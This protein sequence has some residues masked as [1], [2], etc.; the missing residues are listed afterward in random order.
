MRLFSFLISIFITLL[1]FSSFAGPRSLSISGY[2]ENS[3]GPVTDPVLPAVLRLG[4]GTCFPY[5]LNSTLNVDQGYFSVDLTEGATSGSPLS[6]VFNL[7]STTSL[8]GEDINGVPCSIP[9]GSSSIAAF[10]VHITVNSEP[11]GLIPIRSAA[12]AH[13]AQKA[14]ISG[15]PVSDATPTSGQFLR[16][17]SGTWTAANITTADINLLSAEYVQRSL[18]SETCGANEFLVYNGAN[19]T[20]E[21]ATGAA[22]ITNIT[23]GAG[24]SVSNPTGPTVGLSIGTNAISSTMIDDGAVVT[25]KIADNSVTSAKIAGPIS[26][27]KGGTGSSAFAPNK[28]IISNSAGTAFQDLS[29]TPGQSVQFDGG[30]NIICSSA[31]T[32]NITTGTG[33]SGGPITSTGTISLANTPVTAGSY[34]SA[35]MIPTFTVDPQGRLTAA[36]SVSI[37]TPLTGDVVGTSSSTL[38]NRIQGRDVTTMTPGD[39]DLLRWNNGMMSWQNQA[40]GSGPNRIPA[41]D[42][43]G[44]LTINGGTSGLVV[45]GPTGVQINGPLRVGPTGD[46]ISQI[47][48]CTL[49]TVTSAMFYEF[50]CPGTTPTSN[51]QCSKN[52]DLG[53]ALVSV[54]PGYP[55]NGQLQ[56]IFVGA[57]PIGTRVNC[58][59]YN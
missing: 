12:F 11:M 7:T 40:V 8:A 47:N 49:T 22:G 54:K 25:S 20:C 5:R 14:N 30:G 18:F 37:S 33:L 35:S 2:L 32:I 17:T 45:N 19:F 52:T 34:G 59:C 55:S 46:Q 3:S 6:A 44:G 1:S 48:T 53:G 27:S 21:L 13:F 15:R 36:G 16:M 10:S 57:P 4:D 38:V 51:C 26:V 23:G 39:G 31:G 50:S 29:C 56:V 43:Q 28:L 58:I 24:L 42:P 9:G 41:F